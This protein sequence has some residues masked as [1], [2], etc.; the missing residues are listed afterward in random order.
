MLSLPTELWLL[1]GAYL[2]E[3]DLRDAIQVNH[4]FHSLLTPLLYRTFFICGAQGGPARPPRRRNMTSSKPRVPT[5]YVGRASATMERLKMIQSSSMRMGAIKSCT[6]CHFGNQTLQNEETTPDALKQVLQESVAFISML[7][8]CRDIVIESVHISN[9]QLKQLISPH[10]RPVN[11]SARSL[12]ILDGDSTHT[13]GSQPQCP[14]KNLTICGLKGS[15]QSVREFAEWSMSGDL[16]SFSVRSVTEHYLSFFHIRFFHIQLL[17]RSFPN[18]RRLELVRDITSARVL[19]CLPMLEE[20]SLPFTSPPLMLTPTI[21]PR[22]RTFQGSGG[23]ARSITPGRPIRVLHVL[24]DFKGLLP[25][26]AGDEAPNFGSTTSILELS[27]KVGT[28][29]E[30]IWIT[31]LCPSLQVFCLSSTLP[32]KIDAV[33]VNGTICEKANSQRR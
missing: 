4:T 24:V 15:E 26:S 8:D 23:Q 16:Q 14:L 11:L 17:Q 12:T 7:P 33:S 30:V 3:S 10:L 18:L 28:L 6:L 5:P 20:L 32:N 2:S 25:S 31:H 27:V 13:S 1:I 21:L 22:L 9:R 19:E 29:A